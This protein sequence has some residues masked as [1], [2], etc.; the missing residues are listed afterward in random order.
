MV[1]GC[2]GTGSPEKNRTDAGTGRCRSGP[3][4][5]AVDCSTQSP[6]TLFRRDAGAGVGVLTPHLLRR[7]VPA[8]ATFIRQHAGV[9]QLVATPPRCRRKPAPGYLSTLA[10]LG[11]RI[12]RD[13]GSSR[14][15]VRQS[16]EPAALPA[17]TTKSTFGGERCFDAT[18]VTGGRQVEEDSN[19]KQ[20]S[21][22]PGH[23]PC[24]I[25]ICKPSPGRKISDEL[26]GA[27]RRYDAYSC[28]AES[29][30]HK[31]AN[32]PYGYPGS[33]TRRASAASVPS[34]RAYGSG[35]KVAGAGPAA[36]QNHLPGAA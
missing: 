18:G 30:V 24:G 19:K 10:N 36:A 4:K 33:E 27:A 8:P 25:V 21:R 15:P 32:G 13:A 7:N 9:R 17:R 11:S 35:E 31:V 6:A 26:S 16:P 2:G 29:N 14:R 20:S 12:G 23:P 34:R 3:H 1:R 28:R 5:P 22:L